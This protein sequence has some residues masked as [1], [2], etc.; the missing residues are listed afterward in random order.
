MLGPYYIDVEWNLG[1]GAKFGGALQSNFRRL[2]NRSNHS[3]PILWE[4]YEMTFKR[5]IFGTSNKGYKKEIK[6]NKPLGYHFKIDNLSSA[7]Q[8]SLYVTP[9]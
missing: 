4:N 7:N 3:Y 1:N 2:K 9:Q 5:F 8:Y 6:K